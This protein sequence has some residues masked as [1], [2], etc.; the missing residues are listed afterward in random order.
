MNARLLICGL[1]GVACVAAI[2]GVAAQHVHLSALRAER[3]EL[4]AESARRTASPDTPAAIGPLTKHAVSAELLRLRGEVAPLRERLRELA[5]LRAE[6]ETLRAQLAARGTNSSVYR[7]TFQ[8]RSVG[9]H[10]PDDTL[11]SF[12]WA[13]EHRD[14]TNLLQAFTPER[15]QEISAGFGQYQGAADTY[16]NFHQAFL[17][18]GIVSQTPIADSLL[19]VL[20]QTDSGQ[21]PRPVRMKQINGEWKI[22]DNYVGL[23][24]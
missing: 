18:L 23:M 13:I 8:A 5:H 22:D 14:I 20:V 10:R 2:W 3:Q 11:Q 7:Y 6:N 21:N 17:G 15:A 19:E 9:Y 24:R 4:M 1:W 12:Q 16:F